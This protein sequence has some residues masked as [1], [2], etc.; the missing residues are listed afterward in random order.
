MTALLLC[1]GAN[2]CIFLIF[3]QIPPET[4]VVRRVIIINYAVSV[5][6]GMLTTPSLFSQGI[7]TLS[8]T[9]ALWGVLILGL[10]FI[11]LFALM[12]RITQSDGIAV[13]TASTKMSFAVSVVLSLWWFGVSLT[14]MHWVSWGL[15]LVSVYL[16]FLSGRPSWQRIAGPLMLLL[17][18]ALIE[19]LLNILQFRIGEG[20]EGLLTAM[21]FAVAALLG[22]MAG[23]LTKVPSIKEVGL[24]IALG[25]VNYLSIYTLI[26]AMQWQALS[27]GFVVVII[28]AGVLVGGTVMGISIYK[29][30]PGKLAM[31]GVVLACLAMLLT[32][33]QLSSPLLQRLQ[34]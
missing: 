27:P 23:W 31:W 28:N 2:L 25:M 12:A 26:E 10:L 24:G 5:F 6:A 8:D 13:A 3:K 15:A 29:E 19:W 14:P 7:A 17:G 20:K 4:K 22:T 21:V 18:S 34:F 32:A 33:F 16:V 30:K 1:I 9:Y 11:S